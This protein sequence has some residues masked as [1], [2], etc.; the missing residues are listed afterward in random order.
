MDS[1]SDWRG[2]TIAQIAAHAGVGTATV[3]RVV[4]GRE[5]VRPST[6]KK[7]LDAIEQLNGRAQPSPAGTATVAFLCESGTSFNN[8]LEQ[9]VRE[10]TERFPQLTCTFSK[11][12]T[13]DLD[14]VKFAQLIERTAE[15]VDGLVVVA[16]EAI[17]INRA[18]RSASR[19]IPLVTLTTD[20]PNSGRAAYIGNDQVSAG[21]TAACL[22][23]RLARSKPA[24]I[25]LAVSA[26]Y[27]CQEDREVGFR[28]VLRSEFPHL[29]IVDRLN[30]RD[31]SEFSYESITKYIDQN[32]PMAGIY[33]T[34]EGNLGIGK[35]LADRGLAGKTIFIGH[36]LNTN[37]RTLLETGVMDFVIGHDVETEVALALEY[38]TAVRAKRKTPTTSPT[39]LR[40]YTKFNCL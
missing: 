24:R 39:K 29:E 23:G 6:R 11:T 3:D 12:T 7:V 35:A 16:R 8:T 28:R 38:L 5:S 20:L 14:P 19:R 22:M 30:S 10:Q 34:A 36:E 27:R 21:A 37:S 33:N 1:R 4:N 40:I 25:L 13:N 32:G 31:E 9:A 18:L 26:S 2:P 17:V 15:S